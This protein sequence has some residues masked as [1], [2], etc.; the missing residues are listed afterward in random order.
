MLGAAE[1]GSPGACNGRRASRVIEAA[2][3]CEVVQTGEFLS[4]AESD[5]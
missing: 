5:E 2:A 3:L 1:A 4:S